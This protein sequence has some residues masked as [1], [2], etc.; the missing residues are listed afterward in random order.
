MTVERG[1]FENS[2]AFKLPSSL[3]EAGPWSAGYIVKSNQE[4]AG[5]PAFKRTDPFTR[6]MPASNPALGS[7]VEPTESRPAE[8]SEF[9]FQF[10]FCAS[11][12]AANPATTTAAS[13][14]CVT[15]F[16]ISS[17]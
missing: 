12:G 7:A 16:F 4:C 14:N 2:A 1:T 13:A 15:L 5:E 17:S 8:C 3:I 10:V 9:N 6:A 11:A